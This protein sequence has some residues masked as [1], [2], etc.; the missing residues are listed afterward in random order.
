MR[1]E[2]VSRSPSILI[3]DDDPKIREV[4]RFALDKE[5]YRTL[6]AGDG[7]EALEIFRKERPGLIILDILMPEMDGTEVCRNLRTESTV[8]IIFLSSKDDEIDRIVGLELGGDDYVA[9]PFSPRELIARVRAVLRRVDAAPERESSG[10]EPR[11]LHHGRLSL[12]LD[13]FQ[14]RWDDREVVLTVTEFGLLRTLLAYPG[15]V[16]TR[17]ELMERAYADPNV[18]SG[19]TID[20]HIRRVRG[21]LANV[22]GDVIET[23]HGL[24]YK[25]GSCD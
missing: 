13:R 8:P 19:R 23:V 18:V 15:K 20:S 3:V 11:I 10:R 25:I 7:A 22:G 1:R 6:E 17:E 9:K 2:A 21:K 5:G 4:V 16:Y 14:V 24:G 12:D